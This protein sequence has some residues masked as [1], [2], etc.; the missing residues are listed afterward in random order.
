MAAP[1]KRRFL[2]AR[3][4]LVK[5]ICTMDIQYLGKSTPTVNI[6]NTNTAHFTMLAALTASEI[7]HDEE[8]SFE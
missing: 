2:A 8:D 7:V 6:R 1:A 4:S 5:K 3:F